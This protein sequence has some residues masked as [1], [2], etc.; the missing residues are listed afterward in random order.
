MT[1][2]RSGYAIKITGFVPTDPK[3]LA[4]HRKI[5]D[6]IDEAMKIPTEDANTADALF[7]LMEI[8]QFDV[9]PVT[10]RAKGEDEAS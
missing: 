2:T 8:E 9:K 1:T 5:L 4:G 3:D 6:A 10:R 7:R